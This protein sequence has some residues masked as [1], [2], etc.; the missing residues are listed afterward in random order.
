[1]S[2]RGKRERKARNRTPDPTERPVMP[3]WFPAELSTTWKET[4]RDLA[5]AGVPLQRVDAGAIAQYVLT[6]DETAKAAKAGDTK[7][8]ARL[9][10]DALAW[11]A[12]I[13]ASPAARARLNIEPPR[14]PERS[15]WDLIDELGEPPKR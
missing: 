11:A 13:G 4:I 14:A 9:G 7:L 10:R 1:L 8:A 15:V 2:I 3:A 6:M 5:K 12:A